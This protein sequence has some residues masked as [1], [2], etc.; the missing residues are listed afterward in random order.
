LIILDT[1]VLSALMR[2]RPEPAVLGWLDGQPAESIWTTAVTVFEIRLGLDLLEVGRRR[3]QLEAAFEAA[4]RQDLGGRIVELDRQC[5]EAAA[6]LSA[7]RSRAG[8]TIEIRDAFIAG[9]CIA[10]K[11]SLATRNIKHF[12]GLGLSLLD[13]W[14]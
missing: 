11:A 8:L 2:A 9:I 1:N 6:T 5:A 13:P 4:L 3:K 7:A 12:G 10:R 14:A